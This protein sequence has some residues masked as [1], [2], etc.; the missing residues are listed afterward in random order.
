MAKVCCNCENSIGLF[1]K[2]FKLPAVDTVFCADCAGLVEPLFAEINS[3]DYI[4]TANQHKEL[5][6]GFHENLSRCRLNRRA[7]EEVNKAFYAR[8]LAKSKMPVFIRTF[9]ADF[10]ESYEMVKKAGDAAM[11]TEVTANIAAVGDAKS[12]TF[13]YESG[14]ASRLTDSLTIL[15]LT[16]VHSNGQTAVI[17]KGASDLWG[18]FR[19][20]NYN[21]WMEFEK[22]NPQ[23]EIANQWDLNYNVR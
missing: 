13:V 2:P 20:M 6:A 5:E 12:A 17:S 11:K 23:I 7:K 8:Q 21:F 15:I 19:S 1:S 16:V 22:Q 10:A 14:G 4:R 18:D 9:E 3:A